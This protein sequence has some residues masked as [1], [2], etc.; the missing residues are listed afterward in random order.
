MT[1]IQGLIIRRKPLE[2]YLIVHE[3]DCDR[4]LTAAECENLLLA[5]NVH[6]ELLAATKTLEHVVKYE[7][8][9]CQ[10]EGDSEGSAVKMITLNMTRDAIAKAE[11]REIRH[12]LAT[13]VYEGTD[14]TARG[15]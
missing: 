4:E 11:G 15:M 10:R 14:Q 6:D 2:T 13:A 8:A 9:K 7:I 3:N 12:E 1:I 5:A